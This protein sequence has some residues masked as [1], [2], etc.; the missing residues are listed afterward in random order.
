MDGIT[1]KEFR[2]QI[3]WVVRTCNFPNMEFSTSDLVLNPKVT[4]IKVSDAAHSMPLNDSNGRGRIYPNT[5]FASASK[6]PHQ[7][8]H[9]QRF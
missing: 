4:D 2:Q 7:A 9:S 5:D 6:V 1:S 8:S 3:S